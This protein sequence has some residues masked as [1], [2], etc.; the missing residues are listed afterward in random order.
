MSDPETKPSSV[1]DTSLI[2]TALPRK[3]EWVELVAE[4]NKMFTFVN[5]R[6]GKRMTGNE[7]LQ[8]VLS[9]CDGQNSVTQLADFFASHYPNYPAV[10]AEVI[11]SLADA[12]DAGMILLDGWLAALE[13][14]GDVVRSLALSPGLIS[15]LDKLQEFF[16]R[17]LKIDEAEDLSNDLEQRLGLSALDKAKLVDADS[18]GSNQDSA[19]VSYGRAREI[20]F[21]ADCI[22]SVIKE[23]RAQIPEIE[24]ELE[25]SG[26]A[27]YFRGSYMG[28]HSNHSRSDGRVYCTWAEKAEQNFFR[29]Q[30]PVTGEIIT[31][32]EQ[33][34]W[35]IK[36]FTIPPQP[37]RF[38]HSIG[39]GSQRLSLGFRYNLP[40]VI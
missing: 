8:A 40:K 7:S 16:F 21:V 17:E 12:A 11:S 34:G 19:V 39:A 37:Y 9:V 28:W 31:E 2:L 4:E 35:N 18:A 22:Q 3:P 14:R 15:E 13:Y 38:W 25:I 26:N 33:Q 32:Y 6:T 30:D 20:P 24:S 1:K 23:V 10:R 29:Y 5:Q 36:S 27:I